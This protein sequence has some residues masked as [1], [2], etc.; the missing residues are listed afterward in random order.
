M[1]IDFDKIETVF[2]HNLTK[3][4]IYGLFGFEDTTRNDYIEI[5]KKTHK[6]DDTIM[7]GVNVS[8]YMLYMDRGNK[9]KAMEYADKL[10]DCEHKW[11]SV[12]NNCLK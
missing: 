4:E 5:L 7:Y 12:L 11:F 1:A 8:L 10:P 9:Q 3:D 2:E 6:T